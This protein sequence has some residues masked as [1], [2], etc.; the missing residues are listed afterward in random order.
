MQWNDEP[1]AGF[2]TGKPWLAINPN[3]KKINAAEQINRE[4]SVFNY[5]KKLIALRHQ[6]EIIVYGHYELLMPE[7]PDLYVYTREWKGEK[8]LVVCNLSEN[9]REYMPDLEFREG[10]VLIQNNVGCDILDGK[11]EPYE[12]YVL[13][14]K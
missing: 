10:E 5:Y 14:V 11:L 3:Y 9:E 8:L 7:D 13:Y 1:G 2:T 12:A 4:D 6:Y